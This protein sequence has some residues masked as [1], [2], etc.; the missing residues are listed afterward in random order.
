MSFAALA[1]SPRWGTCGR[2]EG[3][4]RRDRAAAAHVRRSVGLQS[5]ICDGQA[6]QVHKL[7]RAAQHRQCSR[8]MVDV[9]P[10]WRS[11]SQSC[12]LW[13]P[14]VADLA[15]EFQIQSIEPV[16]TMTTPLL[17]T[18]NK[19]SIGLGSLPTFDATF[20]SWLCPVIDCRQPW[21]Q[22]PSGLA[23]DWSGQ[24]PRGLASDAYRT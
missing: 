10:N 5:L 17:P 6:A 8:S 12:G 15:M 20:P 19:P 2:G 16:E 13:S 7:T 11:D 3:G 22:S 1:S 21:P 4:R 18:G 24:C 23:S 14:Q 9:M